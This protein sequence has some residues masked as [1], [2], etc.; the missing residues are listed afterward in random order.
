MKQ[1][2]TPTTLSHERYYF[3]VASTWSGNDQLCLESAALTGVK[4]VHVNSL[5]V[6]GT[7]FQHRDILKL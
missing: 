4:R 3:A 6:E 5:D 1:W 2:G 7:V